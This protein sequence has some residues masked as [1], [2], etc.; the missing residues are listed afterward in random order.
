MDSF[1]R[2]LSFALFFASSLS[3]VAFAAAAQDAVPPRIWV[4]TNNGVDAIGCGTQ[5]S[6]CRSIA[7]AVASAGAGDAIHVG[8]GRYGDLDEDGFLTG[9]GEERGTCGAA[10]C[11]DKTVSIVSREGAAR[12][13]I[14]VT[15]VITPRDGLAISADDVIFGRANRGF[16]VRGAPNVGVQVSGSRVWIIDNVVTGAGTG[17]ALQSGF[18]GPFTADCHLIG[19]QAID[20]LLGFFVAGERQQLQF[21]LAHSNSEKGFSLHGRGQRLYDNQSIGNGVGVGISG[22]S[23][24]RI[25]RS[26]FIGNRQSGLS[27]VDQATGFVV[28]QSNFFGNG[29]RFDSV[30]TTRNVGLF[31]QDSRVL[32]TKNFWGAATGPGPDPADRVIGDVKF[33]PFATKPFTMRSLDDVR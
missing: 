23:D 28:E 8:P 1:G 26:A 2:P 22:G 24:L 16:T 25:V 32:A 14:D 33:V 9:F 3:V 31:S 30:N 7:A 29:T 11:V 17:I 13:V 27:V 12:T 10:I 19:N 4:V 6:P 15:N 20:N 5:A 21:N 18:P